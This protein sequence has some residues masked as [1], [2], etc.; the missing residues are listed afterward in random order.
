[1]RPSKCRGLLRCSTANREREIRSR[2]QGRWQDKRSPLGAERPWEILKRS[3]HS[4][5]DP[6]NS[7][8][9]RSRSLNVKTE[10]RSRLIEIKYSL[11][12]TKGSCSV[13]SI[14]SPRLETRI[15]SQI[16]LRDPN[17]R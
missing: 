6:R 13:V 15:Q 11:I 8:L 12:E 5:P 10:N 14:P 3:H 4:A 16:D 2:S 7:S 1:N 17:T 9:H